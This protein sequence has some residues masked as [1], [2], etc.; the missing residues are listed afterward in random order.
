[1]TYEIRSTPSARR[2]QCRISYEIDEEVVTVRVIK[3][4]HRG[5]AY[6]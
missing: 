4:A 5:D 1:M 2:G 3:I 6:R